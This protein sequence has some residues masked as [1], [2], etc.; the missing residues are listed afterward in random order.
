MASANKKSANKNY[1]RNG[2]LRLALAVFLGYIIFNIVSTQA[3]LSAKQ[4]ELA[5]LT[6]RCEDQE[7][8]NAELEAILSLG[9]TDSYIERVARDTLGYVYPDERVFIDTGK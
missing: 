4:Q 8:K 1:V 7:L 3:Q 2:L 9:G 6:Q 5:S